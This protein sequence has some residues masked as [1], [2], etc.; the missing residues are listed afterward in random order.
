MTEQHQLHLL[1]QEIIKNL[2]ISEQAQP[3]LPEILSQLTEH[4]DH[5]GAL[6]IVTV[7]TGDRTLVNVAKTLYQERE[8]YRG[9]SNTAHL[10]AYELRIV[11][12]DIYPET[13][14]QVRNFL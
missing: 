1:A 2:T 6:V 9:L 10:I 3:H 12:E 13:Y 14:E 8:K 5:T 7:M 4:N 11:V